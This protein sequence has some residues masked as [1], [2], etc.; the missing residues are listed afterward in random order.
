M[1]PRPLS[2]NRFVAMVAPDGRAVRALVEDEPLPLPTPATPGAIVLARRDADAAHVLRE[3]AAPGTALAELHAIAARFGVDIAFPDEVMSEVERTVADPRLDAPELTDLEA[4]PFVTIDSAH[5]KDLDQAIHVAPR[6]D[7]GWIVRYAIADAGSYVP[8]GSAL[9]AEALR[10]GASYYLPGLSIPMLP[11]PLSEGIVS[12][13]PDGPRR[14]LVFEM[15]LDAQGHSLDTHLVRARIRSRAKLSFESVQQLFDAPD[16]SE[17]KGTEME[18]SLRAMA[19]V[20]EARLREAAERDVVRYRRR[21]V[22]VAL[23]S[24]AGERFVVLEGVRADVELW[25]EQISL[26][27]NAEGARLLAETDAPFVQPIYRIHPP[28]DPERVESLREAIVRIVDAHRLGDE[29]KWDEGRASLAVYVASLPEHGTHARVARAIQRQAILTNV[30]SR[31]ATEPATHYG[32][33]FEPYARFSAP[34]R[35]VVG[36]YLHAEALQMLEG[37]GVDG[38]DAEALRE[39]VVDAANRSKDVQRAITDLVN[40]RV[41][42]RL[43]EADLTHPRASRRVWRGTVMGVAGSKLHVQLDDPGIDVKVYLYDLAQGWGGVWLEPDE[44]GVVL[45]EQKT[46]RVRAIVGD[47]ITIRVVKRD[48]SRDRWVLEALAIG[49]EAER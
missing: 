20:G 49:P 14:A 6:P 9:F 26:L 47:A 30:R 41:I 13:N 17:L 37:R 5:A 48:E 36:V 29:W 43:F 7:G 38:E 32:A 28:P 22:D 16:R 2:R 11:R 15:H 1:L 34:M 18:P 24:A 23:S 10:R 33:G 4:L 12:L 44:H 25:N 31:Y 35:E 45:R 39:R 40:R 21:D 42:D 19:E 3:L 46:K 8:R 27:C